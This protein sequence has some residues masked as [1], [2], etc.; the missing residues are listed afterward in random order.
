MTYG[1]FKEFNLEQFKAGDKITLV[2]ESEFGYPIVMNIKLDKIFLK[3][4]AQYNNCVQVQGI[5]KGKRKLLA[6]LIRPYQTFAIFE[7]YLSDE[8][9][10]DFRKV[11]SDDSKVTVTSYG[12]C[13]ADNAIKNY[14]GDKTPLISFL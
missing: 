12:T 1:N 4:W 8:D 9:F 3:D 2:K 7:G 6:W 11:V 5:L 10:K 13:F 14:I